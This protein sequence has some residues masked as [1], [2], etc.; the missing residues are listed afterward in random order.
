MCSAWASRDRFHV[1]AVTPTGG[2]LGWMSEEGGYFGEPWTD[3]VI[4]EWLLSV[5]A[6][7]TR[8]VDQPAPCGAQILCRS[9]QCDICIL[10]SVLDS[11]LDCVLVS[12][13]HCV[14]ALS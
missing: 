10:D 12:V 2:H 3:R 4:V 11:V 7:T 14:P 5:Q 6:R 13:L 8:C 1:R 9:S